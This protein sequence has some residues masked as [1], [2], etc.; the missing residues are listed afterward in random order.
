MKKFVTI[1]ILLGISSV[2]AQTCP[3]PSQVYRSQNGHVIPIAPPGWE[4]S[5]KH[6]LDSTNVQF[7]WAAW[8]ERR[9][10][11]QD[12]RKVLC[13]YGNPDVSEHGLI[14][15]TKNNVDKSLIKRHPEW[16]D[17]TRK[18][19]DAYFRCEANNP[20]QCPFG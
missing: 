4:I 18:Q 17:L 3:N 5:W 1:F 14:L 16:Q 6:Q 11:P 2:F 8:A 10:D 12:Q 15:I 13:I 20:E 19:G 7:T 9:I